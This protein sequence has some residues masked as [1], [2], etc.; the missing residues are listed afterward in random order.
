MPLSG[1]GEDPFWSFSLLELAFYNSA[2]IFFFGS[3]GLYHK[4]SEET[5]RHHVQPAVNE[6][7]AGGEVS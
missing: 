2:W 1:T 3:F 7:G 4:Y 5:L 6:P